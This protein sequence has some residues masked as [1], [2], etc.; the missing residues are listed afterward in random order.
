MNKVE[1]RGA[2]LFINGIEIAANSITFGAG[3]GRAPFFGIDLSGL[4]DIL[5][6]DAEL[7]FSFSPGTIHEAVLVLKHSLERDKVLRGS[8]ERSIWSVLEESELPGQGDI[9]NE[10][11]AKNILSRIIGDEDDYDY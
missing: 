3:S 7:R 4:P 10:L 9:T 11:L 1:I 8:F 2:N 5:I 6:Q